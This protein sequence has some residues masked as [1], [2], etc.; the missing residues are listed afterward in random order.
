MKIILGYGW[1]DGDYI[2]SQLL[3]LQCKKCHNKGR[4]VFAAMQTKICYSIGV[5][6]Q[7]IRARLSSSRPNKRGKKMYVIK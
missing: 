2:S 4:R 5:V 7:P 1:M 6:V 3:L